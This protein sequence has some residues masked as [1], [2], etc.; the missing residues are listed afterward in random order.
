MKLI[1]M[2]DRS[3][4]IGETVAELVDGLRFV[5][6]R[7]AQMVVRA[8][9]GDVLGDVVF[10]RLH[11]GFKILLATDLAHVFR[12]EVGSACRIHSSRP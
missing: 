4:A 8:V 9:H 7:Q 1:G 3:A 11:E 6:T 10:E 12:R 5:Q 2:P